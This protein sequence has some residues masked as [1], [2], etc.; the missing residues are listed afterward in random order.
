MSIHFTVAAV[1]IVYYWCFPK[2]NVAIADV[3]RLVPENENACCTNL[4]HVWYCISGAYYPKTFAATDIVSVFCLLSNSLVFSA[5]VAMR[6]SNKKVWCSSLSS[7]SLLLL[8][9]FFCYHY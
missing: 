3:R 7:L 4:P 1:V 5:I 8:L 2:E 9:T 6:G